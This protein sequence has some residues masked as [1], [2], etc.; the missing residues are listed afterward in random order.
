MGHRRRRVGE[1]GQHGLW[2]ILPALMTCPAR[3]LRRDNS[4]VIAVP[5]IVV[6]IP[7]NLTG[8]LPLLLGVVGDIGST[9][10]VGLHGLCVLNRRTWLAA[11]RRSAR[12]QAVRHMRFSRCCMVDRRK[13]YRSVG[14]QSHVVV[15]RHR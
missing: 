8:R 12:K 1:S 15:R 2:G 6:R 3:P 9:L 11:I 4:R 13:N 5:L 7:I 14:F 10:I